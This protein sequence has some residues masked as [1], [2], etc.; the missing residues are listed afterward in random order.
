[1]AGD[2]VG[3]RSRVRLRPGDNLH[4]AVQSVTLARLYR[5]NESPFSG[6]LCKPVW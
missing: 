2:L 6:Q 1:M 3:D 5:I 4:A